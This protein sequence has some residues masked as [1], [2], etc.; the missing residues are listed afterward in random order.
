MSFEARG[1]IALVGAGNVASH[2]GAAFAPYIKWVFSRNAE[3]A[4]VLASAIG[5][6]GS[7]D[8]S[9]LRDIRPDIV[10]VSVADHALG[11]VVAAIGALDYSPLVVHTSGSMPKEALEII[12]HRTGIL[13]P[14]QTFSK[15]VPVDMAQV[16]FFNEA[17]EASDLAIID[18]LARTV[19]PKVYHADAAH[20]QALHVAGVF[21]SNFTNVLLECVEQVLGKAGYTLDVVRPL[22]EATVAKA[23]EVGPHAA[24]TGP[25]RRGDK[26]VMAAHINLLD[27]N[28]KD[29]YRVLSELIMKNHNI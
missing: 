9:R 2:V 29:V 22:L 3:H 24:Q 28:K 16:P 17:S 20:R 1:G 4:R 18:A 14:L 5:A 7:G 23:F 13:Y 21:T 19:S 6:E 10:I 12:S 11:D 26:A 25:A 8:F 27:D 15:D